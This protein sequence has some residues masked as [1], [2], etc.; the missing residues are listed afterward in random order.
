MHIWPL[1]KSHT[2][3]FPFFKLDMASGLLHFLFLVTRTHFSSSGLR[4]S[5][6]LSFLSSRALLPVRNYTFLSVWN[7]SSLGL[8]VLTLS[9]NTQ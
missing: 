3:L 6:I 4:N 2:D 5:S 9:Q 7:V 1:L 8:C